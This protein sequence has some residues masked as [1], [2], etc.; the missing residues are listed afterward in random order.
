MCALYQ[1]K[2]EDQDEEG[3][4]FT[5]GTGRRR[6][7]RVPAGP[8]TKKIILSN[9]YYTAPYCAAFNPSAIAKAKELGYDLQILDGEGNQ[10]KQLEH[11]RLA[12]SE[13]AGFIYF[14]AEF[15]HNR[16]NWNISH[17]HRQ[18]RMFKSKIIREMNMF[19]KRS[20]FFSFFYD[21]LFCVTIF[22]KQDPIRP[23]SHVTQLI[24]LP[25][26]L[27][28]FQTFLRLPLY[29]SRATP[30]P[31]RAPTQRQRH[32]DRRDGQ[33]QDKY[34]KQATAD[35]QAISAGKC[36]TAKGSRTVAAHCKPPRSICG[37]PMT[38]NAQVRRDHTATEGDI[39]TPAG[40]RLA[41]TYDRRM[42]DACHLGEPSAAPIRDFCGGHRGHHA[43]R[44]D[45][46]SLGQLVE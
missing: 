39:D 2:E 9:A 1:C 18:F 31:S 21:I 26:L 30:S 16:F 8:K 25:A 36:M 20:N 17:S 32:T 11:A 40:I 28:L 24:F 35:S 23:T 5:A 12:I 22:S 27:D 34:S 7:C 4:G 14:P 13:G 15:L 19:E 44:R 42:S 3:I 38:A 10:Q 37:P 43:V 41:G 45:V 46:R 29:Q 6:R 33:R